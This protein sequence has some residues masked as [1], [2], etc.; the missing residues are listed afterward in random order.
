MN[1]LGNRVGLVV[2]VTSLVHR[3]ACRIEIALKPLVGEIHP[4][5]CR[6]SGEALSWA[7]AACG[8]Q[9]LVDDPA[10]GANSRATAVQLTGVGRKPAG[11]RAD[12]HSL[13]IQPPSVELK[14]ESLQM[15]EFDVW[16]VFDRSETDCRMQE[17]G[18]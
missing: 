6:C 11:W 14:H 2:R 9:R 10:L 4:Q 18:T 5:G 16:Q 17:R 7:Y 1:W 12:W 15:F 13:Y 3:N 8:I